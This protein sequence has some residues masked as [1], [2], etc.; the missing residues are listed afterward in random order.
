MALVQCPQCGTE[1]DKDT[2]EFCPNPACGYPAAFIEAP[3]AE[4]TASHEMMRRPGEEVDEVE[5]PIPAPPP[6]EP[7]VPPEPPPIAGVPPPPRRIPQWVIPVA[8]VVAVLLVGVL[9]FALASG[10]GGDVAATTPSTS[11]PPKSPTTTPPSSPPVRATADCTDTGRFHGPLGDRVIG[12]CQPAIMRGDDV[13]ELQHEL[14]FVLQGERV[15]IE[16]GD[17]GKHTSIAVQDYKACAKIETPDSVVDDRVVAALQ[18]ERRADQCA[19]ELPDLGPPPTHVSPS[20]SPSPSPSL[21][22]SPSPSPAS[23]SPS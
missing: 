10:G 13:K 20:P 9:I 23:P 18:A 7:Q 3:P 16:D 17:F 22:L 11:R 5:E 8:A 1:F 2:N 14:N 15:L 12:F 19:T 21:S 6:V 4:S